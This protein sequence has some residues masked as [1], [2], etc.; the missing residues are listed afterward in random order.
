MQFW[1]ISIRKLEEKK[2]AAAGFS[3]TRVM[4]KSGQTM[5]SLD[6][7]AMAFHCLYSSH[8]RIDRQ[9]WHKID[10]RDNEKKLEIAS[11][12]SFRTSF[13]NK[14]RETWQ[15]IDLGDSELP[16]LPLWN[17][18]NM[19]K[20]VESRRI[21]TFPDI[22]TKPSSSNARYFITNVTFWTMLQF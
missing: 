4:V 11:L 22:Q 16:I 2:E 21:R 17:F 1:T 12:Q 5:R 13:Y 3:S 6:E 10:F 18:V 9:K 19:M 20:D 7:S 15:K 8:L 14:P